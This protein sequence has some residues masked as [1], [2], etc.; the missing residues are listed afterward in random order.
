MSDNSN[1]FIVGVV[2]GFYG[3]PWT[4]DQRKD[5]F[6]RLKDLK[7][8]AFMYAPKDD[9]KHRAKWRQLYS[10]VEAPQLKAL[11]DEAKFYGIDFYYSLAPGLDMVYSEQT[12]LDLLIRKY[13][14]LVGLGCK[15][16][17]ILFDDIE[18]SINE[19]DKEKFK[20][21]YA[22]AQVSVANMI[23][24]HLKRPKFLFCPTEY[25]ESRA[26]PNVSNSC[27]LHTLG[28]GL[29]KG[30]D[31]MWS[32][33]RVIS[34]LIT[35]ESIE[36]LTKVIRRPPVIWENLHANDYDKKRVFLG[37]YSGRS[38]N[39]IP[40]LRGVL[41]NP[42]CEYEA[43]YIA[44]HT[45]AQWSKCTYDISLHNRCNPAQKVKYPN[46]DVMKS[47][48]EQPTSVKSVYDP[49]LALAFAIKDWLPLLKQTR[50]L[51]T[52][53]NLSLQSKQRN[54]ESASSQLAKEATDDRE[55]KDIDVEENNVEMLPEETQSSATSVSTNKSEMDTSSSPAQTNVVVDTN[56]CDSYEMQDAIGS[57]ITPTANKSLDSTSTE[58]DPS[59]LN[60]IKCS[61]SSKAPSQDGQY[62]GPDMVSFENLS[63]LVD[64]FYL[65]FEH[66]SNG[67]ILLGDVEW[68][69]NNCGLLSDL[70]EEQ[71]KQ[72]SSD[73]FKRITCSADCEDISILDKVESANYWIETA[74]KLNQ[75]CL[76]ISRL[77]NT[78]IVSSRRY[79]SPLIEFSRAGQC[80]INNF[81]H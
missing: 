27:Y 38:T 8:N 60:C 46:T 20:G 74:E 30:I 9:T 3:K 53:I 10:E 61:I 21:S 39:L 28:F 47:S 16:F 62:S 11:I 80:S 35:V 18:P 41:T 37:P 13:N 52:G 78:L 43:N 33:P 63:L 50:T 24:E 68:L 36:R 12:E 75:L 17:A 49:N 23:F 56:S 77:V 54:D 2:E 58:K 64:L 4:C 19:R 73:A 59:C 79:N 66:G 71:Q 67:N 1:E 26:V 31:I 22:A 6:K 14:Q 34:K 70:P 65:P 81:Y 7:L 51:P 48:I 42:N 69:K 44:I 55:M 29:K 5:L 57:S 76:C 40:K 15:S 72:H 32:G 25:C 45:L